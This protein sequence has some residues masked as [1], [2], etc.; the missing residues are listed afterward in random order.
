MTPEE[1]TDL[2]LDRFGDRLVDREIAYGQA[3]VTV[4]PDV[5]VTAARVCKED[6]RLDCRLFDFMT[7]VDLGDEGFAVITHLYSPEQRHQ[8]HLRAVAPGGREDPRL[9]S[10]TSV[11]R[12]ANWQE[13]EIWDMF[14][15]VFEGHPGLAPRILTVENFEGWPLRK[16]FALTTR[17][18][19]P[20]PGEKEESSAPKRGG[21]GAAS[22]AKGAGSK[23]AKGA[24]SSETS[25]ASASSGSG[26]EAGEDPSDRVARAKAKAAEMRRRKR[27]ER[28]GAGE[29]EQQDDHGEEGSR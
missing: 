16:D 9:P 28:E 18:A 5:L 4:A 19:K 8:V 12:G 11:Y 24:G 25:G 10:I 7:G 2:F 15:I 26:A 21:K 6:P 22:E 14:G 20:W 13:R 29:G 3:T 27:A 17:L 1:I 23:E